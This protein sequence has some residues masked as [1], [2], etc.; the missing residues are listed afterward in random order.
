MAYRLI[1]ADL[2]GTLRSEGQSFSPRVRAAVRQAQDRGVHVVMATG[3]MFRTAQPFA[4]DLGL[5]DPIICD[6][7]ATIRDP[8]SGETLV[9][10]RMPVELAGQVIASAPPDVTL[11]AC[12]DEEF[13]I[14]HLTDHAMAFVGR[15]AGDHL[16]EVGDLAQFLKLDPQKLVF[17]NDP[18]VTSRLLVDLTARFGAVLQVVQSFPRYVELTH[19]D[20]SKGASVERLAKRWDIPRQDVIAIGDQGNDCS[21]IEWAGL[22]VAMGNAIESVKA[23]AGYVAPSAEQDGVAEVIDRYVLNA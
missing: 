20:A 15:Y 19:R 16:H 22:G 3:R 17:V 10:L 5:K 14:S 6:H 2:D 7:G 11:V 12:L 18:D 8:L 23:I 21:M 9:Q 13:Y 1:A 4:L